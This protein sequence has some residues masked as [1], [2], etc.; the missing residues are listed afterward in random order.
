MGVAA[1][2]RRKTGIVDASGN[3]HTID[4]Y[5]SLE[6]GNWEHLA[7]AILLMGAA[8][9]GLRCPN[10]VETLFDAGKPWSVKSRTNI[11][12]GHYVPAILRNSKDLFGV[13]TWG[14]I[15]GMTKGFYAKYCD[16]AV[17]YVSMEVL[18]KKNISPDGFDAL[19]LM[20]DVS[21]LTKQD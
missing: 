11:V 2:Y 10:N 14:G 21:A 16:E 5:V 7:I 18:G 12:G 19:S 8:G 9:V 1:A 3:R 15:Q 20:R 13:I 6:P 4:A 17:A